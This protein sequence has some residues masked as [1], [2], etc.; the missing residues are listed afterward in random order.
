MLLLMLL[1]YQLLLLSTLG[2]RKNNEVK[3]ENQTKAV[4]F[5]LSMISFADG[6]ILKMIFR[7]FFIIISIAQKEKQKCKDKK[8]ES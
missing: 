8:K 2:I 3:R 6:K 5:V 4:S 1:R 7:L